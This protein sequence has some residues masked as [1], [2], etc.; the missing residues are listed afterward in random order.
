[1]AGL[2]TIDWEEIVDITFKVAQDRIG[3]K[4]DFESA[5]SKTLKI[6][7]EYQVYWFY[8]ISKILV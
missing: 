1:M 5:L 8:L 3:R 6:E 4:I 7:G 2:L